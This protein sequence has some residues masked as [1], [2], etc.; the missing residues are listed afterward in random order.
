[1]NVKPLL[2]G[3]SSV[4][5]LGGALA[6]GVATNA[7]KLPPQTQVGGVD[8]GGLDRV[9]A[10][11]KVQAQTQT[12][13]QIKVQASDQNWTI[14]ADQLGYQMDAAE[15]MASAFADARERSLVEKVQDLVGQRQAQ[16]YPLKI[17][18][19]ATK[20]RQTLAELS[21]KLNT[22]PVGGKIYFD[23]T[24]YAVK[25]DKPGQRVDVDAAAQALAADPSLRQLDL[26]LTPWQ[27]T[28][29]A[30]KLQ[31]QVDKGNALL[32][33]LTVKLGDTERTGVLSALKVANM[34]WVR[35]DGIELDKVA[36]ERSLKTLSGYLDQPAQNARYANQGGKLVRVPERPGLITDHAAAQA[37][38]SKAVLDASITSLTLPSQPSQPRISLAAL[39]DPTKLTL[40]ATGKS[41]YYHS[42]PERRTNV[43]NAAAKIDGAVVAK[44]GVF[45]F[46]NTLGGI[47]EGNG[48]V[49]GLIISGGRTVDGLGGG[50]CQVSTTT[51][52]ALYQAGLPVVERN[53]HSYRVGYYEPRVG[54]EAAVYDPGLDLKMKND[55]GGMML[56]R[57]VNNNAASTLEVQV[58]GLPQSRTVNVSGATI[59]G[60]TPHPAPKY[61]VNPNLP[62]G[63]SKQVDWA[64]DGFNLYITRTIKDAGKISTD[65]TST[66]YKPWQAVYEL[67]PS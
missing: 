22:A 35:P 51:F 8:V 24:H 19:D 49:G 9:A 46:L 58:W 18:V 62:R 47:S 53:Q 52:R 40:I 67:G 1:M 39:P 27:A 64:A 45:S 6:L 61:I 36:I 31:A 21:S 48:F 63:A 66:I 50:V 26:K 42:S 4:A 33:P 44:E 57:A 11:A 7:D 25:P 10:L 13:P 28:Y 37:A 59:L 12:P 3:L 23:K 14:S 34:F 43:A 2:I 65:K 30:A 32:R 20:A 16:T 5:V 56:I 60:R 29:T 54:F 55:T 15:S 38:L 17:S 41:T